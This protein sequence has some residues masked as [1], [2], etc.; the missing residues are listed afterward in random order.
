M[1][2]AVVTLD[3]SEWQ[4]FLGGIVKRIGD[5]TD[6]LL[7]LS[8]IHGFADIVKH[9]SDESGPT[10]QWVSRKES[11]QQRY[12]RI[13]SGQLRPPRGIARAAF[14]PSNKLLQLTGN[15]RQSITPS[16]GQASK[17]G[18]NTVE[19]FT[20]VQ[21]AGVHQYGH[22]HIPAR[23]FMWLSQGAQENI[24]RDLLNYLVEE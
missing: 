20:T 10:Q 19:L 3:M 1:A 4:K 8:K 7:S 22:K 2:E 5:A 21:Y 16:R 13:M 23:P 9:F 17:K 12:Q 6:V 14:N 24:V 15:L 11:T 18:K